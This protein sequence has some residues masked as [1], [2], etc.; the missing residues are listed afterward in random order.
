MSARP[1]RTK[2]FLFGW[3]LGE[4]TVLHAVIDAYEQSTINLVIDGELVEA[5]G[6]D[7]RPDLRR[8]AALCGVV[9]GQNH[10]MSVTPGVG[11]SPDGYAGRP[12]ARV[13][14]TC[15]RTWSTTYAPQVEGWTK[16]CRSCARDVPIT[17]FRAD[18]RTKDGVS[19]TCEPC[20]QAARHAAAAAE[21][22]LQDAARDYEY[23][24]RRRTW[25]TTL[26]GRLRAWQSAPW[27]ATFTCAGGHVLDVEQVER[28]ETY[29]VPVFDAMNGTRKFED[30][31][32]T[33]VDVQWVCPCGVANVPTQ[34]RQLVDRI[35]GIDGGALWVQDLGAVE[36]T[37]PANT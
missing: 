23:L 18:K 25:A 35:D 10:L 34:V 6:G 28:A 4:G 15:V 17:R 2:T 27:A 7:L 12:N 16:P 37:P 36:V 29:E 14:P 24:Q 3:P 8:A 32:R 33:V 22:V 13:C 30:R 31:T 26:A 20:Q 21:R 11:F 1:P 5:H 9:G 19:N